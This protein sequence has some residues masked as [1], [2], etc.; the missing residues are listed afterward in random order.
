MRDDWGGD[1]N[2]A[3]SRFWIRSNSFMRRSLLRGID[4]A[5]RCIE[6][7]IALPMMGMMTTNRA[8][9]LRAVEQVLTG[10]QLFKE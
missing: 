5:Y 1:S 8:T 3:R 10:F 9:P 6:V 2:E 7:R 4:V